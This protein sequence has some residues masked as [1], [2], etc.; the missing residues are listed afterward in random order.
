MEV[1]CHAFKDFSASSSTDIISSKESGSARN[2][3]RIASTAE[4][5]SKSKKSPVVKTASLRAR[6]MRRAMREGVLDW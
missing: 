3:G 1:A 4:R 6:R 2:I 5:E